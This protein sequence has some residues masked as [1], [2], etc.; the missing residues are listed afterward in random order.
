M[1]FTENLSGAGKGI[2]IEDAGS[3]VDAEAVNVAGEVDS[4]HEGTWGVVAT[5]LLF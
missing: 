3:G 1:V 5:Y 2:F 4:D